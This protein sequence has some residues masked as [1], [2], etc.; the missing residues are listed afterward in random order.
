MTVLKDITASAGT[1]GGTA[2]ISN[3][4]DAVDLS[5][6]PEPTTYGLLSVGLLAIGY[7]SRRRRVR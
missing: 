5:V 6:V 7:F 4:R 2:T 1:A 3:V